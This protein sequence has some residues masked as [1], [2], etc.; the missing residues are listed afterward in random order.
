MYIG[1][2]NLNRISVSECV[3]ADDIVIIAK[4]KEDLRGI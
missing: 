2:R 1:Y 3:F 4:S